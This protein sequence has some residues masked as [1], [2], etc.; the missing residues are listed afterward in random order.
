M[1]HTLL[2]LDEVERVHAGGAGWWR[3]AAA[4]PISPYEYWY[5]G[6]ARLRRGQPRD[7]RVAAG[8]DDLA[9]VRDDPALRA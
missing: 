5:A 7:T 8:D 3:P 9:S 6:A 4:L 1:T 2:H